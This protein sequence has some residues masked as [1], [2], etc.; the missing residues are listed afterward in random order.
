[1]PSTASLVNGSCYVSAAAAADAFFSQQPAAFTSGAVSY[2]SN[3]QNDAGV[4]KLYQ[5][6]IDAAGAYTLRSATV[7]TV[8][9][10]PLCDS[11]ES[12][13]DGMA[14]GWGITLAIIAAYSFTQLRKALA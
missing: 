14:I 7:A 8:P 1:M 3:F 4:W 12:F 5:Y 2:L 11:T 13:F 9:T 6:S 10:F